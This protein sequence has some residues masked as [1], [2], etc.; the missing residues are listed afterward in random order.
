MLQVIGQLAQ[1]LPP[2]RRIGVLASKLDGTDGP[3]ARSARDRLSQVQCRVGW[4]P[5]ISRTPLGFELSAPFVFSDND[6]FRFELE[7]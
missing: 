4:S 7:C 2:R 3:E 6:V 1:L 5:R